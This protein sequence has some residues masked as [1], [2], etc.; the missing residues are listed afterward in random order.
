[1]QGMEG[2]ESGDESAFPERAGH[3]V[4]K[5][6][7]QQGREDMEDEIGHVISAGMQTVELIIQHQRQPGKRVPEFSLH[8]AESPADAFCGYTG[9]EMVIFGN[10]G[11]IIED[12]VEMTDLPVDGERDCCQKDTDD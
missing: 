6:E 11:N 8:C 2:E 12:E 5:A 9:A 4:E 10:I 7:E 1:M 3:P